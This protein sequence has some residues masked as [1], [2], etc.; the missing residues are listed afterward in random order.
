LPDALPIWPSVTRCVAGYV[1]QR[2]A[3]CV[4]CL[5]IP[6]QV[7]GRSEYMALHYDFT[8]RVALIPGG[9]QGIGAGIAAAFVQAGAAVV[10]TA[11][12]NERLQKSAAELRN[13]GGR[14]LAI[15]ADVTDETGGR[16][17]AERRLSQF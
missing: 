11:R 4:Q 1:R 15:P 13:D 5:T 14:V 16:A 8:D 12:S 2:R 9:S 7:W 3:N 17:L 6:K 10:I